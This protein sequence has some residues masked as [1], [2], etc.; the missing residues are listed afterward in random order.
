MQTRKIF[1]RISKFIGKAVAGLLLVLFA[2][3]ILVHIPLVQR[4]ITPMESDYL[5]AKIKSR[6][7]IKSINFSILGD[8]AIEGL[9]VWD[10]EQHKIF[11]A[12]NIVVSSNITDLITGDLIFDEIRLSGVNGHL[13]ERESGLNI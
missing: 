10:P 1:L 9:A 6:V 8:V 2:V 11:S 12:E 7:E 13:T 3:V 5:S 4:Q